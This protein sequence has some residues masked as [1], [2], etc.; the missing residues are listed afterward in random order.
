MILARPQAEFDKGA[1]VWNFLRL[2]SMIGLI[3]SHRVFARL[4][5]CAG[6]V[7]GEIVL[8]NQRLLNRL[9]P[10]GVDLLLASHPRRLFLV[11]GVL[12]CRG[13]C[14]VR[15]ARRFLGTGRTG[16]CFALGFPGSGFGRSSLSSRWLLRW[17]IAG[18]TLSCS[19]CRHRSAGQHQRTNRANSRPPNSR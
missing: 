11:R 8:A 1:R 12:S 7:S 14:S 17:S 2:P 3:P 9:R 15:S 13:G 6:G 16:F 10:F 19:G 5:P 18:R 4:V